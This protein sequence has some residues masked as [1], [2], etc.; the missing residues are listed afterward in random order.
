MLS[1]SFADSDTK[2]KPITMETT[3]TTTK[4]TITKMTTIT[5]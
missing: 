2:K 5:L 1:G 4:A 3:A